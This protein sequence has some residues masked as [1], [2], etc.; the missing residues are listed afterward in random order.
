MVSDIFMPGPINTD[1]IGF[2]F[3]A[4]SSIEFGIHSMKQMTSSFAGEI[5]KRQDMK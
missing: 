3:G 2:F 5:R 4:G 1:R